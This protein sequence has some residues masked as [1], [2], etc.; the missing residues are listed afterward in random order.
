MVVVIVPPD[1]GARR[2]PQVRVILGRD[3]FG[4]TH[5]SPVG[6][7]PDPDPRLGGVSSEQ[8]KDN[9][10]DLRVWRVCR[11]PPFGRAGGCF[12]RALSS[13][14]VRGLRQASLCIFKHPHVGML[15]RVLPGWR[16]LRPGGA[17]R[18]DRA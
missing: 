6:A 3:A 10:V 4:D 1:S 13:V 5:N 9:L 2:W 16:A 12:P 8:F 7:D 15:P 11:G 18:E 14:D 17:K